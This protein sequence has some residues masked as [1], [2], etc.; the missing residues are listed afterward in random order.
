MQPR[1]A[2]SGAAVIAMAGDTILE[3]HTVVVENGVVAAVGPRLTTAT[4]D[5]EVVDAA[6]LYLMPGLCDMHVHLHVRSDLD[7][8][9]ANGITLVRDMF[10]RPTHLQWADQVAAGDLAGP[11]I[12]V[13]SPIIDGVGP[14]GRS[15]WPDVLTLVDPEDAFPM[16][17]RLVDQGYDQVK[18]YSWLSREAVSALGEA[19]RALDIRLVGHCPD[20]VS[21]SQAAS[22]GQSCFEHLTNLERDNLSA[23]AAPIYQSLLPRGGPRPFD[24]EAIRLTATG[25]DERAVARLADEL[26]DS[27]TWNC[28]TVIVKYRS[29]AD[30]DPS[31][32][33]LELVMPQQRAIWA[34]LDAVRRDALEVPRGRE[35]ARRRHEVLLDTVAQLH[36]SGAPLLVGTDTQNPYV[37]PGVSVAEELEN[38]VAAGMTPYQALRYAT[39]EPA[40]FL[41]ENF[42]TVTTGN[43]ADLL[44]LRSNPLRSIGAVRDVEAVM[45]AGRLYDRDDL[46][47][48]V[49]RRAEACAAPPR[50]RR[51]AELA[52]PPGAILAQGSLSRLKHGVRDA[53]IH[54]RCCELPEAQMLQIDE[55]LDDG[56]T[57][58]SRTTVIDLAGAV[59]RGTAA[60]STA[61]G[62]DTVTVARSDRGYVVDT[63]LATGWRA[64]SAVDGH[65]APSSDLSLT[66]PAHR[67]SELAQ[68]LSITRA[69]IGDGVAETRTRMATADSEAVLEHA[70]NYDARHIYTRERGRLLRVDTTSGTYP[71]AEAAYVDD[72]GT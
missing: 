65:L 46:S 69:L 67:R 42:G 27:S 56:T 24:S 52:P 63:R 58:E 11:R 1:I 15:I 3:D 48:R 26:A 38:F 45:A 18:A 13:A 35:F 60:R 29:L 12:V 14:A 32:P 9:L 25:L 2:F 43:R 47:S 39:A 68:C 8:F 31:D 50:Q 64:I 20:A 33:S 40:R 36:S 23:W 61:A 54:Y 66:A 62:N 51:P 28:A 7:L 34:T 21:M 6:G 17:K 10:G 4:T 72:G 19:C 53:V 57:I 49:S 70:A 71:T 37:V 30:N 22:I 5:C 44:L 41:G 59:V 55:Q 16:V